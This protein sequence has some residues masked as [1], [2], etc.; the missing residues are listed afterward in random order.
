MG[1]IY[2]KSFHEIRAMLRDLKDVM[3]NLPE[4]HDEY[5]GFEDRM[6]WLESVINQAEV[7]FERR[8]LNAAARRLLGKLV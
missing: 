7:R 1:P 2:G 4:T 5:R 3:S 6:R 8:E